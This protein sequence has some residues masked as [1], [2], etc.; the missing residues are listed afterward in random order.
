MYSFRQSLTTSI[1][2]GAVLFVLT[3]QVQARTSRF[4]DNQTQKLIIL[5]GNQSRLM[6]GDPLYRTDTAKKA[7]YRFNP[8]EV[9]PY[10]LSTGWEIKSVVLNQHTYGDYVYGYAI[11]EKIKK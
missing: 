10:L 5:D 9:L 4:V 11:V 6:D 7:R 3:L 8:N 1:L 2:L